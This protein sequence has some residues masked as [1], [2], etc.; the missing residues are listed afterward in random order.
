MLFSLGVSKPI[1]NYVIFCHQEDSNWPLEEGK[2][3]KDKFD[4]IFDSAKYKNCL[5]NIRDV[6]KAEKEN[7]KMEGLN[8]NHFRLV[9]FIYILI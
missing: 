4:E 1:L 6:R 8:M 9:H 5:N 7:L 3:V 2:K